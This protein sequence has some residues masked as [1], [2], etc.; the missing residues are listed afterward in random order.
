MVCSVSNLTN[1]S[2][3]LYFTGYNDSAGW[4]LWK[5]DGTEDGTTIVKDIFPGGI[6]VPYGGHFTFSSYPSNLTD[7]DGTLFFTAND[8]THGVEV[9]KSD[10]TETRHRDG[11]GHPIRLCQFLPRQLDER[12]RDAVLLGLRPHRP[13]GSCGRA[14]APRTARLWSRTSPRAAQGSYPGGLT[15]CGRDL[16]FRGERRGSWHRA[17]GAFHD[18]A[19]PGR[20]RILHF[21]DRRRPGQLHR[22][23]GKR[24][25]LD[26]YQLHGNGALH[27]L[28]WPG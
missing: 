20:E 1:V 6:D 26:G 10:G 4:E 27:Q 3:T 13:A 28:R 25:W 8:G 9:W 7:V 11:Q 2:G 18:P 24:R 15:E 23:G 17:V 22:D 21:H 14:T 12:E 5:S 16:V 19:D